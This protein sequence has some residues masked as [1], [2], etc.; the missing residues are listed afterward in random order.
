MIMIR[1]GI[2][3]EVSVGHDTRKNLA[4]ISSCRVVRMGELGAEAVPARLRVPACEFSLAVGVMRSRI[5]SNSPLI[6]LPTGL[7]SRNRK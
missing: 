5:S 6:S 7:L 4:I 1:D 3:T 2:L